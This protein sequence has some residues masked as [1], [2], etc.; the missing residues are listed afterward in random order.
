MKV[1]FKRNI[2]RNMSEDEKIFKKGEMGC[3]CEPTYLIGSQSIS[4]YIKQKVKQ[5]KVKKFPD[6]V[7]SRKVKKALSHYRK[8]KK[9]STCNIY[10]KN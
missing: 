4:S 5:S 3:M 2:K 6:W 7:R 1:I 8:T 10:S 9:S